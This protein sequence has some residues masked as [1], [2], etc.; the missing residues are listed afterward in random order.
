MEVGLVLHSSNAIM[1]RDDVSLARVVLE[2]SHIGGHI[3]VEINLDGVDITID[4]A[5][6]LVIALRQ[7]IEHCE[8]N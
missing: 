6:N 4:S 3:W 8:S 5:K 2:P 7:V 1:L